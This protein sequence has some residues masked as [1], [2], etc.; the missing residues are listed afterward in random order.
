MECSEGC[1]ITL[2]GT[3]GYAKEGVRF[4]MKDEQF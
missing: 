4:F 1:E 2:D 3:D